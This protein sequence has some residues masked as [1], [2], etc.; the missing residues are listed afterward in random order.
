MSIEV[1]KEDFLTYL[2]KKVVLKEPKNLYAPIQ[3]ILQIGGK[4]LRPIL[5]IMTC[6]LFG[7]NP[8]K[9]FDAA[10]AIEVF[11]NFT[12]VHDDIMDSAPIRRGKETVHKK[13]DV[14][15]GILS[16][17]AMMIMA[18]Q[19]FENYEPIIY[20]KLL[21]L[22]SQ[23]ALEVCEGQQLDVDFEIRNDVTIL[24]YL[25]MITY[26]TSVLVAASMKMGAIIAN[27]K[28][29][30]AD[31]I[32]DFGLNLGIAFQLQDDF[33]DTFGD[34]TTFGKK[35]GGDIIENKKTF[36][37]LKAIE[38]CETKDRESLLKLYNSEN[39]KDKV[40]EVTNLFERNKIPAITISEI[41]AYTNKAFK[42]LDE[43]SISEKKK[44]VLKNFG[45][46][47]MKRTI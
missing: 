25:K 26:K 36:L 22:F 24:E 38:V 35:I 14:N 18:Y 21:K 19:C 9:A 46:S 7:E 32:Y 28:E 3:Y 39:S 29:S 42:V 16:G 13:W 8:Q 41:E 4:R 15:T 43:L 31:S 17:D 11:H 23:T 45:L 27:V 20:K 10:L 44:V 30:E 5:A 2:N 34:E 47:L 1:Y 12:L 6:D 40:S 37:Y 33:L